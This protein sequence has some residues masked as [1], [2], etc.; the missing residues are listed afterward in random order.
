MECTNMKRG[1]QR[2]GKKADK[3]EKRGKEETGKEGEKGAFERKTGKMRWG[4]QRENES[5]T[6]PGLAYHSISQASR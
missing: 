4:K 2:E 5:K 3:E 6:V 1:K